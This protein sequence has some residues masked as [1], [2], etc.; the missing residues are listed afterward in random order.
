M[1]FFTLEWYHDFHGE[2][3]QFEIFQRYRQHI[4][5]AM[6]GHFLR[7]IIALT[8]L[9]GVDDGL[10]VKVTHNW[11]ERKLKIVMRCGDNPMGYYDLI[12]MYEDAEISPA[13]EWTLAQ[14]AR[15]TKSQRR[16]ESDL[17]WH[18]L[19]KTEDGRIEHGFLFHPGL[20]F[21]VTCR[22]LRWDKISRQNRKLPGFADRF[23]DGP[24][25]QP[26]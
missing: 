6:K 14:I 19:N 25:V 17:A 11:N 22:R 1:K 7:D 4:E 3:G 2:S 10:I 15:S 13:D 16:H 9:P 18:E 5:E 24:T 21:T 12:L 20:T 26:A 23:P 8:K